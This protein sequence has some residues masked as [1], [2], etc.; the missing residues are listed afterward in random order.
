MPSAKTETR[1]MLAMPFRLKRA[2]INFI[3]KGGGMVD[4]DPSRY[5]LKQNIKE[6]YLT[7]SAA[8]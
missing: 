7:A 4:P 2:F 8:V 1:E 5:V 6:V 3:D